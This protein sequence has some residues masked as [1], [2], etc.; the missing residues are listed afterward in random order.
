MPRS[1][2]LGRGAPSAR[3]SGLRTQDSELRTQ[4]SRLSGGETVA[5]PPDR[6][7]AGLAV[8]EIADAGKKAPPL[9]RGS[10]NIISMRDGEMFWGQVF[11]DGV[12]KGR[13]PLILK[14][15]N[16]RIKVTLSRWPRFLGSMHAELQICV[17]RNGPRGVTRN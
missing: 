9:K 11:L 5:P 6:L 13:T 15:V 16:H 3:G 10:V 14:A 1:C 8:A 7:D 12:D 4:N 2:P 17:P